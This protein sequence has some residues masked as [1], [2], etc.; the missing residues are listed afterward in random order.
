MHLKSTVFMWFTVVHWNESVNKS[1]K[2][3]KTNNKST[4]ICIIYSECYSS[5]YMTNTDS[6]VH[7]ESGPK[8]TYADL[9]LEMLK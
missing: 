5:S 8:S 2:T 4:K 6:A 1:S 7:L 3:N 9:L